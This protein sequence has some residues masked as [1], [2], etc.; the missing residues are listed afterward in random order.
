ML[1]IRNNHSIDFNPSIFVNTPTN[2][3]ETF[4]WQVTSNMM[5]NGQLNI[6]PER[7]FLVEHNS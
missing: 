5:E 2:H 3:L 1:L 6:T 7:L 4:V